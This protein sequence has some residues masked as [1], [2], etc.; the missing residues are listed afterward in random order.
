MENPVVIEDQYVSA[1]G[2]LA[3]EHM[4]CSGPP[5]HLITSRKPFNTEDKR[6]PQKFHR[7]NPPQCICGLFRLHHAHWKF[8]ESQRYAEESDLSVP[9]LPV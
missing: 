1:H 8:Q 2:F 9:I 3:A 6:I 7:T 5:L 4:E